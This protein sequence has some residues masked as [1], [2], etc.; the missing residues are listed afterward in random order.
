MGVAP[1]QPRREL[2]RL[3]VKVKIS[4]N[5][6]DELSKILKLLSPVLKSCKVSK[7]NEGRFKRAYAELR[8]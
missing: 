5:T 8:T 1:V 3:S 4:Y 6:E 7:E 2:T